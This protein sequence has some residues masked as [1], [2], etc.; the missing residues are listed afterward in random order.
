M[1]NRYCLIKIMNNE[2][3]TVVELF[4]AWFCSRSLAGFVVSNPPGVYGCLPLVSV[5]R[6]QVEDPATGRSLVQGVTLIAG[7]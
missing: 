3:I 6:G 5:V 4:K 2:P 7:V 1:Q